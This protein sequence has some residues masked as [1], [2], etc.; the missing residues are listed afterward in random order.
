[1]DLTCLYFVRMY[2]HA[3]NFVSSFCSWPAGFDKKQ[4]VALVRKR[5]P[6]HTLA[7]MFCII[8]KFASILKNSFVTGANTP[9]FSVRKGTAAH[10]VS[11]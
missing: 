3:H 1:M 10:S 9:S 6:T 8:Y 5:L 2:A 4:L 11:A 7:S